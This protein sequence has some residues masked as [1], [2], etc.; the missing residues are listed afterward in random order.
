[1]ALT[2]YN[3]ID[4]YDLIG[5]INTV[6]SAVKL[7]P[8]DARDIQDMDLFPIGG[9]SKRN[10][11][12]VLNSV[13]ANS[14]ATTGL[15]MA[16]YS[17][18]GGT[19]LAYLISGTKLYS[20]SAALGGTWTDITGGLTITAGANNI[21][22]FDILN[23]IVVL[24]NGTDT[25]IQINSSGV[26]STLSSGLPFTSFKFPLMSRG[27]MFYFV[28]TVGGSVLYDRCYF[29]DI[30]DPP[31]VDT[32]NFIDI[33]KRQGGDVKGAVEY[34]TFVYVFKRHGIYQMT[35]QP[36]QV[37]S[38]GDFFPWIQ[39]PSPVVPGVGTQSHRSICKFTTPTT[40]ATPGQE[41]VFFVDQFGVPRIFDGATTISFSSKIGFSRDATIKSL[42][43]M[44]NTR[45]PYCFSVNYPSKNRILCF[46]SENDSQQ[47]TCWVLDY[48]KGF[49]ICRYDFYDN[50]N[51][52]ALFEKSDGTFK[53]YFGNYAGQVFQSDSGT[54]DNGHSINDYYV[55]GDMFLKSP[56]LRS[57]W[58]L[59]DVRGM[60]GATSENIDLEYYLDG[61][62]TPSI[63]DTQ[64]LSRGGVLWGAGPPPMIWGTS[65]WAISGLSNTS[66]EID[67][68]S[69]TIRIKV[70]SSDKLNDSL[71]MEG[72]SLAGEVLGTS[73][74]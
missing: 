25:P 58:Y 35:F 63:Q 10:G 6:S 71:I 61:A 62:D 54:T 66:Y 32:N 70:G 60:N 43:D 24:G 44:D 1:M 46:M 52:G 29:S 53:P 45:A 50:F 16:R 69:K 21:W 26:A 18:A 57:K 7:T 22:N 13:P 11:Y 65:S 59:I 36:T 39:Y 23:D 31:T 47:D 15:Y 19:N 74:G 14:L 30:N 68:E 55:T 49:A 3:Y 41:L 4:F 38:A 17:T 72:F 64:S 34:K 12:A 20:M 5:G 51:V 28:P 9:F 56:A 33:G 42:S 48:S 73:I 27:Y 2:N 8:S 40:H 67:A 37:N